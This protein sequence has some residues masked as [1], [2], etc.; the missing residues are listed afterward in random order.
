MRG[1]KGGSRDDGPQ[2]HLKKAGTPTMG[3]TLII[4][5]IVIATLLWADLS[6]QY[7]WLLLAVT[8]GTGAPGFYDDWRQVL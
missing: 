7:V 8:L 2:T 4:V 1:P 6:N 5:S 3:G